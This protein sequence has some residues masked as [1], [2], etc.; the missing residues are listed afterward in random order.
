MTLLI[1]IAE[2]TWHSCVDAAKD[3]LGA[4]LVGGDDIVLLHPIDTSSEDA[5]TGMF[6]GLMGRGRRRDADPGQAI[7]RLSQDAAQRLLEQARDR[8]GRDARLE[9]RA[10]R[11]EREV[12]EAASH[13]DLLILA[14][15]GDLSRLGP[16]SLGKHTRFVVD[17]SPCPVLLVWPS[18]A[19]DVS[20]IPPPPDH[21]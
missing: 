16:H 13:A 11:P 4:P 9:V 21:A 2:G 5:S 19:P 17:H 12:T 15:D 7:G 20:S 3:V 10:G 1:W 8:L 18:A 14:R 6:S